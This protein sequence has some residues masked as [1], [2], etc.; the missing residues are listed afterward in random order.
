MDDLGGTTVG[1]KDRLGDFDIPAKQNIIS[2]F[3]LHRLKSV[4]KNAEL[5]EPQ[6]FSKDDF[7]KDYYMPFAE[8]RECVYWTATHNARN[9]HLYQRTYPSSDIKTESKIELNADL[10]LLAVKKRHHS[11]C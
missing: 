11:F 2:V 6:R 1:R 10:T 5:F 7:P 9:D 3:L 8:D 4:W